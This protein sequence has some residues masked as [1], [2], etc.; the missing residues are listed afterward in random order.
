MSSSRSAAF[1]ARF[2][3]LVGEPP[4]TYLT[5]WRMTLAADRLDDT[6][7]TVG[8]IARAVGYQDAFAFSVAFKRAH[9]VSP[10]GW[11]R[12]RENGVNRIRR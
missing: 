3:A 12:R 2:T 5:A 1:A 11:R 7:D 8:V 4:L 6:D 10:S 9:G